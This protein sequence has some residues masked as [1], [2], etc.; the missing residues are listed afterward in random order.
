MQQPD[1]NASSV[2]GR[3]IGMQVMYI[4]DG[5]NVK[6]QP[7]PVRVVEM[8]KGYGVEIVSGPGGWRKV[9]FGPTWQAAFNAAEQLAV[10]FVQM[11][12]NQHVPPLAPAV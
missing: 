2:H 6:A 3:V 10:Q 5:V 4:T 1:L 12:A 9:G 11:I 7:C 8:A